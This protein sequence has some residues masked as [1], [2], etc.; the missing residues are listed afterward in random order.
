[1]VCV[2]YISPGARE[3]DNRKFTG[4]PRNMNV[5]TQTLTLTIMIDTV[6]LG[7]RDVWQYPL[8]PAWARLPSSESKQMPGEKNRQTPQAQWNALHNRHT[9]SYLLLGI[10]HSNDDL[11]FLACARVAKPIQ[12]LYWRAYRA[13]ET[14]VIRVFRSAHIV[15]AL[16][17]IRR[18]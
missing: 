12:M 8:A 14:T 15:D 2:R 17:Q 13:N 10:F 9:L 18:Y 4:S 5:R 6:G 16:S 1:M 7:A 11:L 3:R